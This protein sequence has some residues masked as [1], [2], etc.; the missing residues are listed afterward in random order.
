M[1]L[2]TMSRRPTKGIR[3]FCKDLARSIPKVIRINRGKLNREGLIEKALELDANRLIIVNRWKGGPGKIELFQVNATRLIPVSPLLYVKGV[4]LQREFKGTKEKAPRKIR[5]LALSVQPEHR[6]SEARKLGETL[7][8]FLGIPMLSEGEANLSE[9]QA[10]LRVFLD[11]ENRV[12]IT[13]IRLPEAV[14]IGPRVTF[15]HLIWEI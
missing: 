7:S 6:E 4:K 5:S 9:F 14:E 12:G 8:K 11:A 15:S 2:L 1:I 3:T 13:F 10:L